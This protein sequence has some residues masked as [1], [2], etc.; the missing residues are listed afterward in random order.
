MESAVDVDTSWLLLYTK[1]RAEDW[2]EIQLRKR[3][4]ATVQPR[5]RSRSGFAPLYPRYVI[6]GERAGS[7]IGSLVE[8]LGALYVVHR[9]DA[10]VCVPPGVVQ[11]IRSRMDRRG[12]VHL[13]G[14][15][16]G[17]A[18]FARAQRDRVRALLESAGAAVPRQRA[19][20]R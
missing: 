13:G 5:V 17:D 4:F 6:V 14:S 11:A 2:V 15:A 16:S 18:L 3:G 7:P 10:V 8:P 9:G 20:A 12:V 1:G 19:V